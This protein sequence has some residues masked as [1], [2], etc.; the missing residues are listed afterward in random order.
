MLGARIWGFAGILTL[1]LISL[2]SAQT[3]PGIVII[4]SADGMDVYSGM[5]YANLIG[6]KC[7]FI[8]ST[9]HAPIVTA[10]LGSSDGGRV[11][12][13]ESQ[14]AAYYYGFR[15]IL[16]NKGYT[17]DEVLSPSGLSLNLEL[18]RRTNT[19]NFVVID[20][21]YGYNAVSVAPYAKKTNS[22][23]LLVNSV[24]ID[25]VYDFLSERGVSKLLIYGY[26]ED[27][28]A[29]RLAEFNPERIYNQDKYLD[30]IELVKK[31]RGID[32]TRQVTLTDGT[33]LEK[34]FMSSVDPILF[35]AD[36]V[37]DSVI[38]YLTGNDIRVA[39][40]IGN[41]VAP[42]QR[43]RDTLRDRGTP[44]SVII[45]FGQGTPGLMGS[46]ISYLDVFPL[47]KYPLNVDIL[48]A[49]Y[50]KATKRLEVIYKNKEGAPAWFKANIEILVNGQRVQT[51][52]DTEP[53]LIERNELLGRSY[54]LDLSNVDVTANITAK[55]TILFGEYPASL[56]HALT[57]NFLV[58]FIERVDES[59]I[60]AESLLY[61]ENLKQ[62][63][64]TIKNIGN[65]PVYFKP[66]FTMLIGGSSRIF[67]TE[68]IQY[69]DV[70]QSISIPFGGVELT[71]EDMKL[72]EYVTVS[73]EYGDREA[74]LTKVSEVRV[75][76][77]TVKPREEV[78]APITIPPIV[79]QI[80]IGVVV[81][82]I[83]V[84]L[85]KTIKPVKV[86]T[87]IYN[88]VTSEFAITVKNKSRNVLYVKPLIKYIEVT[89]GESRIL[90]EKAEGRIIEGKETRKFTFEIALTDAD[91]EVNRKV[92]ASALFGK[93]LGHYPDSLTKKLTL[94]IEK[95]KKELT[96]KLIEDASKE[97]LIKL[98]E[99]RE[100]S[101]EGTAKD[102]R[103]RL[104]EFLEKEKKELTKEMIEDASRDEL[105]KL[106][107]ERE[108]SIEGET[109]ELRERLVE[110]LKAQIKELTE[111]EI[112]DASK[113]ELIKLCEERELSTEGTAKDLRKRLREYLKKKKELTDEM[114]E[115]ASKEE[116]IKLCEGR[117][118]STEGTAKDLR[119]RLREFLE[120]E[121]IDLTDEMI[122]DASKEELIKLCT[123]SNL[124]TTG[125]I[126]E[127]RESLKVL[128]KEKELDE[129]K[130][131]LKKAIE[132]EKGPKEE[133]PKEE[134]PKKKETKEEKKEETK[135]KKGGLF[136]KMFG[137][138]TKKLSAKTEL[139]E[140]LIENASK[141]ELI[142]LCKKRNLSTEGNVNVLRELLLEYLEKKRKS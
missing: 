99:E 34:G 19:R 51:L 81:A 70:G 47:P 82:L 28:V 22:Y 44:F 134:K 116:L 83:I 123:D 50:N 5:V 112:E 138:K 11:L 32:Y 25:T 113:E 64:L 109:S 33:F 106:C 87:I 108:L 4:N 42:A 135:E 35:I 76:L 2:T 37:P 15:T 114:I 122:E 43:L 7:E 20:T 105:I 10:K 12:L 38:D 9:R 130:E 36:T 111:Q 72:N 90:G 97:E 89:S 79:Y 62:L 103:E 117:E 120:K 92:K 57:K 100:L 141:E 126:D 21:S 16:T 17:V 67:R 29:D 78:A 68:E 137:G 127:L 53:L 54:E 71:D 80:L 121:K 107:K 59:E 31:L 60:V 118:L 27:V 93:S 139:T 132:E 94:H 65:V 55:I 124:S 86:I 84:F 88:T 101:T 58:A 73:I 61:D 52:G 41:L 119:K 63:I 30:N 24:N 133:A 129:I 125:T 136:G 46:Q 48:G 131:K 3:D 102:L 39:V 40:V 91:I 77:G 49:E 85:L 66:S 104:K 115:D 69:L 23:V 8:M 96:E 75:K 74:F 110:W 140:K 14:T 98:C 1:V 13:I 142:E 6:V 56:D 45:K 18:A 128:L 95:E 26:V